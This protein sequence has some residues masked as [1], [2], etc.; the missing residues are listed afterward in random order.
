MGCEAD[1]QQQHVL[2]NELT[3]K[4]AYLAQDQERIT[5]A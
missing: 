2:V 1:D 4:L 3:A 5:W